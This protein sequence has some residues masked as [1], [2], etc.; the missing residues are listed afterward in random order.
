MKYNGF[1]FWL[2]QSPMRKVLTERYSRNYAKRI[3]KKSKQVYQELMENADDI[4][5]D[6]PMAYNELF[7][8]AFVAPYIASEK[9]IP[10]EIV[11]EMMRRSLYHVKWYFGMT[12]LNTDRGKA[13]NKK[14][15]TKYVTWYTPE[16]EARYPTSFKVDFVGQPHEEACY[17]RITR[18]PICAYTKKLG[19]EELMT[20]FCELDHVMITLQHGVL[21]RQHTIAEHGDYCDYYITGNKE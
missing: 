6:N 9:K 21:H 5:D 17:Y 1:Y 3:M 13:A 19:V 4:G 8:L 15:I 2:F 18:C 7:A 10:P 16:R 12:D 14:S 20:L 11:Q